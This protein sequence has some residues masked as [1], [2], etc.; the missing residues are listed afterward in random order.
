MTRFSSKPLAK[1]A[2][3]DVEQVAGHVR[4]C[5]DPDRELHDEARRL[6]GK[7]NYANLAR[8]RRRVKDTM[9][10]GQELRPKVTADAGRQLQQRSSVRRHA[11]QAERSDGPG[12]EGKEMR[13]CVEGIVQSSLGRRGLHICDVADAL[14][15]EASPLNIAREDMDG[16]C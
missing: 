10:I 11:S 1:R 15:A 13:Q 5:L 12:V 9:A 2:I 7:R 8:D 16:A 14:Q 6:T 4:K 3:P